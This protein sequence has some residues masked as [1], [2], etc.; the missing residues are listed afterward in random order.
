[1]TLTNGSPLP[2][3]SDR[4]KGF[5]LAPA[6]GGGPIFL[7]LGN[8][9]ALL[10]YNNATSY[11]LAVSHLADRIRGKGEIHTPWP[12]GDRPLR[13]EEIRNLQRMLSEIGFDSN[14]VDGILGPNTRAAVRDFQESEGS[15][16]DGYVS[17]ELIESVRRAVRAR[18]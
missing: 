10:A 5:I 9:R 16:P 3:W 4:A 11:A 6:G 8:F 15:T 14:G 7:V 13:V 12:R 2:D 18:Q 17:A 1:M